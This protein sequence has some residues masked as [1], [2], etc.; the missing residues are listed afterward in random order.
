[1]AARGIPVAP[2]PTP[3]SD[4]DHRAQADPR[5]PALFR[6][7]VAEDPRV[8]DWAQRV[9][10]HARRTPGG[11]VTVAGARSLLLLGPTGTGKTH[12]A[13]G[14]LRA[15]ARHGVRLGWRSESAADLYA[16]LRPTQSRDTER[17]LWTVM[18]SPLLM[19]DDLAAAKPSAWTEEITYR[20]VNHRYA[21]QLPLLITSNEPLERIRTVLGDRVA[22]RLAQMTDRVVLTGPDR[23]RQTG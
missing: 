13:F 5:I 1:M 23:R 21:H 9:A 3:S 15:L 4:P 6:D 11:A 2:P 8:L 17:E 20:V 18:T 22:S 12:Q 7:A 10:A 16:A 14:A 19:I